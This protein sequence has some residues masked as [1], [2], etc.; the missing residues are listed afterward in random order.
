MNYGR[1]YVKNYNSPKSR[2]RRSSIRQFSTSLI[3][4][5]LILILILI[6]ASC[7]GAFYYVRSQIRELPDISEINITPSGQGARVY[8]AKGRQIATLSASGANRG[9]I[10]ISKIPRDLQ[11]AFVASVDR[12]FYRHNGVDTGEAIR[13]I[14]RSLVSDEKANDGTIT[15]QLITNNYF[16]KQT[17]RKGL[18]AWISRRIKT[19]YLAVA[20]EKTNSKDKI[21]EDYLN[22]ICL[23]DNII[24]VEAASQ[25]YFNKNVS[26]LNLS[27]SAVL[28]A[29][30]ENPQKYN[31]IDHPKNNSIRREKI[32]RSMLLQG[33]ISQERYREAMDDNVYSR[34]TKAVPDYGNDT[35]YFIEA[36]TDQVVKDLMSAYDISYTEAYIKLYTGGL[37]IRSTQDSKV[38]AIAEKEVNNRDNYSVNPGYSMTFSITVEK[39]NGIK[40]Y[41][42]KTMISYL[43][44]KGIRNNLVFPS[45]KE[46]RQ[47]YRDYRKIVTKGGRIPEG[48]EH[49]VYTLQPQ[50]AMTIIDQ[51]NGRVRAIVGGR[52][53]GK[54]ERTINRAKDL[55][56]Q[57]GETLGI[58]STYA[59]ALDSGGMTLATVEDDA[60]LKYQDGEAVK[61]MGKSYRG[62]TTI[63]SGI[64]DSVNV[65]AVKAL[66]DIGTGLG[67]QYVKDFGI[68]TL[69]EGDDNQRLA[70]GEIT[71]G[72]KNIELTAAYAAIA[73]GGIYNKPVF[74]TS[75]EDTSGE[76]IL[77]T[78]RRQGKRVIKK[79]SAWLLTSAMEEAVRRGNA[80]N[81]GFTQ[82]GVAGIY[83]GRGD[84]RMFAGF[85]PYYTCVIW[86]GN[87]DGTALISSPFAKNIWRSVMLQINQGKEK[88]DFSMPGAI[89]A[90]RVCR[91]S[92]KVPVEGVCDHDP[93]GDMTYTEYFEKESEP[94]ET[95]DHHIKL[96]ICSE[97]S[98]PATEF[99]PKT[100]EKVFITGGSPG[101]DDG[102]YLLD[103][104][105]SDKTCPL[106]P[107][108][109]H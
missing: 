67:Y 41:S 17:R 32:L 84:D 6:A 25:R 69:R 89:V 106:H 74:Y 16:S 87:D 75:V 23:G 10:G 14:F 28:A 107:G 21:L 15:E 2:D 50:A 4:T 3:K 35:S 39:E 47:A 31:P 22:S 36:M 61:D 96:T 5:L 80:K 40:R 68:N 20:V 66:T 7:L 91:K 8:D 54:G 73:N 42:Q 9:H 108:P 34:I 109:P 86:G 98:L 65:V 78:T 62:F 95:C 102:K 100:V 105:L 101:T 82:M 71:S 49:V 45:R 77:D 29:T 92:G 38:S 97:S 81:A 58:L 60:P 94:T 13:E 88:K 55:T 1:E 46:A 18:S 63:R 64:A 12:N 70:L 103:P 85:T 26:A 53:E 48:G 37:V 76:R 93:R 83:K 11:L 57:P 56:R 52:E 79:T 24:G 51:Q 30:A 27:E 90:K 72:V 43:K 104:K 99:C 19:Q 44:K 33:Y 59:P